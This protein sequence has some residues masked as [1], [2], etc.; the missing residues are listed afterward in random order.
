MIKAK[1]VKAIFQ[2]EHSLNFVRLDH[3]IRTTTIYQRTVSVRW[4]IL[5]PPYDTGNAEGF[6]RWFIG[7]NGR[8]AGPM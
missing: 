7:M 8:A 6:Y 1:T 5:A 3:R 2:R 4:Q